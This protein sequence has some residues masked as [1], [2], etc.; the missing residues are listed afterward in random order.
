[1]CHYRGYSWI[2][3]SGAV[4]RCTD[5][6]IKIVDERMAEPP[7]AV[8]YRRSKLEPPTGEQM[9][10][11]PV[12]QKSREHIADFIEAIERCLTKNNRN[13][14][15]RYPKADYAGYEL[16]G[17]VRRW[18]DEEWEPQLAKLTRIANGEIPTEEECL[19]LISF[20]DKV[21][22]RALGEWQNQSRGGGCF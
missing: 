19:T 22:S 4:R 18:P 20:L 10:L 13:T 6:V 17:F 15:L 21:E 14:S 16:F 7:R 9:L 2:T 5:V 8:T 1:M 11:F 12:E 3:L